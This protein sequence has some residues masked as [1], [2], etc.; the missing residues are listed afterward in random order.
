[1]RHGG[2]DDAIRPARHR[3]GTPAGPAAM[4]RGAAT[5]PM[6]AALLAQRRA[7]NGSSLHDGAGA[8]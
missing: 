4:T 6:V 1:M 2:P 8:R 5:L 7:F 3:H